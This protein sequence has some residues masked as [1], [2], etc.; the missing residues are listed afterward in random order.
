[1]KNVDL[2][3]VIVFNL[4]YFN[5]E[6]RSVLSRKTL[7]P[8]F[9][10]TLYNAGVRTPSKIGCLQIIS[11]NKFRIDINNKLIEGNPSFT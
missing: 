2:N 3:D 6:A 1:M 4:T 9:W 7:N 5:N 8:C 10:E 11:S